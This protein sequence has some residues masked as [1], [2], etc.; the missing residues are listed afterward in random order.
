M[1]PEARIAACYH[2]VLSAHIVTQAE[3]PVEH[4]LS[5]RG[6]SDQDI[7]VSKPEA[8]GE[9]GPFAGRQAVSGRSGVVPEYEPVAQELS[10]D[11][12]DNA[13]VKRGPLPRTNTS[14]CSDRDMGF[15]R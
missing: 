10:L 7:G 3:Q 6:A 5:V 14:N 1:R 2:W 15:L 13:L 4:T 9:E 12:L 8:T 11:R